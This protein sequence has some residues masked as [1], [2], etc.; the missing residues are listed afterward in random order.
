M[1]RHQRQREGSDGPSTHKVKNHHISP[2]P[3]N[4][5]SN[6]LL[7]ITITALNKLFQKNPQLND[8]PSLSQ[9]KAARNVF[10]HIDLDNL[11]EVREAHPISLLVETGN[12]IS[13]GCDIHTEKGFVRGIFLGNFDPQWLAF[14]PHNDSKQNTNWIKYINSN[15]ARDITTNFESNLAEPIISAIDADNRLP[16]PRCYCQIG[17]YPLMLQRMNRSGLIA[18][19]IEEMRST[20]LSNYASTLELT[21]FAITKDAEHDRLISWPRV[22]NRFA[23]IPPPPDLP[24]P[25]L[26]QYMR[27]E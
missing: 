19:R 18:C 14:P 1:G 27:V 10:K 11:S 26:F 8:T 16:K 22:S 13:S 7:D 17:K 20:K 24:D 12:L 23:K 2:F 25:S 21:I 9:Q 15:L 6:N 4:H 5:S 3:A